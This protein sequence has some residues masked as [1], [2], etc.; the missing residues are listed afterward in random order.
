MLK[1]KLICDMCGKEIEPGQNTEKGGFIIIEKKAI[2][3]GKNIAYQPTRKGYDLCLDC[4]KK[5]RGF[6]ED[7]KKGLDK[8]EKKSKIK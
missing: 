8:E 2:F 4:A 7:Y 5:V 1:Q 3:Q 6:I